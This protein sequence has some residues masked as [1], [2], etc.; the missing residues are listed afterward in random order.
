MP[1]GTAGNTGTTRAQQSDGWPLSSATA[2]LNDDNRA[3][4]TNW[5]TADETA[6]NTWIGY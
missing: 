4:V 3:Y 1:N 5:Q 2:T 6:M